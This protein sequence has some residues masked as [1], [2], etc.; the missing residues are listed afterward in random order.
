[1]TQTK[2]ATHKKGNTLLVFKNK[3]FKGINLTLALQT[4]N[5]G[6]FGKCLKNFARLMS[7][8]LSKA[9]GD[10]FSFLVWRIQT[11]KCSRPMI[12]EQMEVVKVYNC[13]PVFGL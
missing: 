10:A 13:S 3:D 9:T 4:I 1:M 6:V 8:Q 12:T 7:N 5:T 11:Y 2:Q